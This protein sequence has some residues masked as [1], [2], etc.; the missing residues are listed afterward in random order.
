MSEPKQMDPREVVA[1]R[2]K[3]PGGKGVVTSCHVFCGG[4]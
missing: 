1:A 3:D 2:V 4:A